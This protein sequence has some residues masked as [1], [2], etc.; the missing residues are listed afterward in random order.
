MEERTRQAFAARTLG[1]LD[2]LLQDL[3]PPVEPPA[4]A[5]PPPAD[6]SA[7]RHSLRV[8][9]SGATWR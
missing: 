4:P 1:E 3:P 5:A 2:G 8:A 6:T 7:P 9:S